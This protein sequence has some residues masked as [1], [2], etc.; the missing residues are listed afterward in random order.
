MPGIPPLLAALGAASRPPSAPLLPLRK[1]GSQSSEALRRHKS[2][3]IQIAETGQRHAHFEGGGGGQAFA[4]TRKQ[5]G[6]RI[7]ATLSI[8]MPVGRREGKALNAARSECSAKSTWTR[9]RLESERPGALRHAS[10]SAFIAEGDAASAATSPS[11]RRMCSNKLRQVNHTVPLDRGKVCMC[12]RAENCGWVGF[13]HLS[14]PCGKPAPLMPSCR[15][16]EDAQLLVPQLP[17]LP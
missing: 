14:A 3:G 15:L 12:A 7:V 11:N 13:T 10:R 8:I 4:R 9:C 1:P 16:P 5:R 6:E 17:Q 2:G